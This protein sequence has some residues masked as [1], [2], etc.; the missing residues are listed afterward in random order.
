MRDPLSVTIKVT[1][2]EPVKTF[3]GEM[4]AVYPSFQAMRETSPDAERF[5]NAVEDLRS[6]TENPPTPRFLDKVV[7]K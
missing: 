5:C 3:L 4:V 7:V 1:E 2:M 6:W